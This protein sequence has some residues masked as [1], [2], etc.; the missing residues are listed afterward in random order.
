[1]TFPTPTDTLLSVDLESTHPGG[2]AT[3]LHT[4][5]Y[6]IFQTPKNVFGLVHQYCGA[7]L[8]TSDPE[9]LVTLDE[10]SSTHQSLYPNSNVTL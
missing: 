1:M 2:V 6:Q 4:W 3:S 7:Q 10:L 9:N 5:I 8:P